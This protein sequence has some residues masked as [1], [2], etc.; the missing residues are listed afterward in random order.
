M[1]PWQLR[2]TCSSTLCLNS[3]SRET[4]AWEE[5]PDSHRV[6]FDK[7]KFSFT[8]FQNQFIIG[9]NLKKKMHPPVI[10]ILLILALVA[11]Q[12]CGVSAF[13]CAPFYVILK[14]NQ[15]L[16]PYR[17]TFAVKIAYKSWVQLLII[18]FWNFIRWFNIPH[19]LGLSRVCYYLR[20]W[21]GFQSILIFKLCCDIFPLVFKDRVRIT[22]KRLS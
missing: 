7:I 6:S 11:K 18:I 15:N 3:L 19:S 14:K 13:I 8:Q 16:M 21:N 17:P 20:A 4:I 12:L 22:F 2:T 1:L 9:S 10:E 5:I